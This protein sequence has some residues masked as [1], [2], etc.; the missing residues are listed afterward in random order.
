MRSYQRSGDPPQVPSTPT[1]PWSPFSPGR[2]AA[3]RRDH[4]VT[5]G[6]THR[7]KS[8]RKSDPHH[9]AQGL[10]SLPWLLVLDHQGAL[11]IPAVLHAH[12]HTEWR[13]ISRNSESGSAI[14]QEHELKLLS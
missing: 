14:F 10:L 5:T 2:P 13:N 11:L 7:N 6:T 1:L 4:L 8:K 12:R 3:K 9:G